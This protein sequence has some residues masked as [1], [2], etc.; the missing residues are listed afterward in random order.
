MIIVRI[1]GGLG[2]Q[3][4]QYAIGKAMAVKNQDCL[5]LDTSFYTKPTH[6]NYELNLFNIDEAVATEGECKELRGSEGLFFKMS[7]KINLLWPRPPAYE[8]EKQCTVFDAE[9]YNLQGDIYLDGFWQN[10]KYFSNIREQLRNEFV[11]KSEISANAKKYIPGMVKAD[12]V[13]LHV[14][15]G[16]YVSDPHANRVH[17]VCSLEYYKKAIQYISDKVQNPIFYIFS[18]DIAWCQENFSFL[19]SKVFVNDTES[20]IDDLML[21]THC[22]HSIIA[23]SSFSWWG[24]WLNSNQN[25][26]VISPINWVKHNPNNL[27]WVPDMWLQ[28]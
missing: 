28:F 6:L 23:N 16:D 2:N 19:D 15:R 8:K 7:K 11:P 21:M 25:S 17:G 3:M 13:C 22:K 1:S 10:E 26:I 20:A 9:I 27:K 18:D 5:K 24:A 4:F 12:S 14:R